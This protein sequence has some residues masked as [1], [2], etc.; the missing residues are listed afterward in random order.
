MPRKS[1]TDVINKIKELLQKEGELSIRQISVKIKS[2][3]RTVN[4]ALEL[5][6]SLNT[7]KE[8]KGTDTKRD[9]RL[10]SLA[11]NN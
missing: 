11:K 1:L 8:R 10:F 7:V 9:E 5:M 3:W 4:K 6:K 2:E